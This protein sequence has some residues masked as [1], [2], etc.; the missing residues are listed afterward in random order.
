MDLHPCPQCGDADVAWQEALVDTGGTMA[1]RYHGVCAGC[2]EPREF[3]FALPERPTPPRP[4]AI[5]TFGS[6]DEASVLLDAGEWLM[7]ADLCAQAAGAPDVGEDEARESLS[8]AVAAVDEVLKFIPP[9]AG[10]VPE[11]AFWSVAGRS[12]RE[13]EPGRFRR[14]RLSVVRDSYVDAR[15]AL[16][17][18]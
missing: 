11:T 1:R 15:T 4:G 13:R 16:G 12:A 6:L 10:A 5:V 18:S 3:V 7:V 17:P 14:D 2:G 8:I 9:T